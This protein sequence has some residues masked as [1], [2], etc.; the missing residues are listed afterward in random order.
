MLFGNKLKTIKNKIDEAHV[1]AMYRGV[2]SGTGASKLHSD[3]STGLQV[4]DHKR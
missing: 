3:T 1:R 4:G 2:C